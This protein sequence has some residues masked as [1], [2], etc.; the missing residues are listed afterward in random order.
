MAVKGQTYIEFNQVFFDDILR[1]SGVQSLERQAAEKVLAA[2]KANAPYDTGAYQ[3]GLRIEKA[4][5]RFRTVYL[6]T[7][8]DPKTLLVESKTGNLARALKSAGRG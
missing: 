7:G 1:E 4:E 2:A 8:T 5:A 3:R 6:V